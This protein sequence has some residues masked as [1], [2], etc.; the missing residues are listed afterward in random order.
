MPNIG[1]AYNLTGMKFGS[2]TVLSK[3]ETVGGWLC[4]CSCKVERIVNGA[5]LRNGTSTGCG[6]ARRKGKPRPTV[7]CNLGKGAK[8]TLPH[9][10]IQHKTFSD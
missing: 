2:W 1:K 9:V 6:H 3:A 5:N 4:R 10:S 7:E 8:V